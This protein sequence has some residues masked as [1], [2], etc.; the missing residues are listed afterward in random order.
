[1]LHGEKGLSPKS[2]APGNASYYYSFT[3]LATEGSIRL[4]NE[5]LAVQGLSWMDHEFG[6]TMLGPDAVGWDWFS[7]QLEDGREVMLFQIRKKDGSIEP[8]S[9]GTLVEPDGSAKHLTSDQMR[10]RPT[11]RWTSPQSQATYPS[12]WEISIPSA[13]IELTLKPYMSDQEMRV[14][15]V[16]W[17]GAVEVSGRSNGAPVRGSGYV[18]MTGYALPAN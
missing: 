9:G 15:I 8:V 1:V 11:A 18:E 5:T 16:Y 17:E 12:G 2:D 3:R 7:I 13:Q 4:G 14:E 6:T 10:V